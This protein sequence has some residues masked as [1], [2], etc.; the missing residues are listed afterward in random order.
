[1]D[2]EDALYLSLGRVRLDDEQRDHAADQQ[3]REGHTPQ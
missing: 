3:G 2:V 1:M